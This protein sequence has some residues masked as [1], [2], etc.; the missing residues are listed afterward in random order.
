MNP[1]ELQVSNLNMSNPYL[2]NFFVFNQKEEDLQQ[3]NLEKQF[4]SK[5]LS[6][7]DSIK[8]TKSLAYSK[9]L[10]KKRGFPRHLEPIQTVHH[11]QRDKISLESHSIAY[12]QP[13][14]E[15]TVSLSPSYMFRSSTISKISEKRKTITNF[16]GLPSDLEK[17]KFFGIKSKK[18]FTN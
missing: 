6:S 4:L 13:D 5:R 9:E 8:S 10:K 16:E 14:Q 7:A 3:E 1:S 2:K 17:S 12:T 15:E 18:K 11:L